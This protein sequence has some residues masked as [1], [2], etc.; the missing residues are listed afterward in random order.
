MKKVIIAKQGLMIINM[1]S[2][3]QP[4]DTILELKSVAQKRFLSQ[5]LLE[6]EINS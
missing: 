1:K 3:N 4:K 2:T 6:L 5:K